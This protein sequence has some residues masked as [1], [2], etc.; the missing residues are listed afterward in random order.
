MKGADDVQGDRNAFWPVRPGRGHG[1]KDQTVNL[2]RRHAGIGN[3]AP[4][5]QDAP[6]AHTGLG[7][8]VPAPG[9]WRVSDTDG[10]DLA[11]MFPQPQV[12]SGTIE[13]SGRMLGGH[14]ALLS[15]RVLWSWPGQEGLADDLPLGDF[16]AVSR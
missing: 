13:G 5:C 16:L 12:L 15:P 3:C 6:S 7:G 4:E 9:R 1:V 14:C 10:R 8:T 11:A 2:V